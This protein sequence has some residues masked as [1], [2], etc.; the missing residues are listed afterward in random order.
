MIDTPN[1]SV[2][3]NY[4][5]APQTRIDPIRLIN[6]IDTNRSLPKIISPDGF[7]LLNKTCKYV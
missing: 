2:T 3:Y 4:L 1:A 5:I 7:F 6:F